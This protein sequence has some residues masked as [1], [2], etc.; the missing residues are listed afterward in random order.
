MP[1]YLILTI[2]A[3]LATGA[4]AVPCPDPS[5]PSWSEQNEI[6]DGWLATRRA[7]LLEM[8]RRHGVDWWIVVNEEFHDDPLTEYVAPARPYAGNR[9]L[10]IFIDTGSRLRAVAISGYAEEVLARWFESPDEPRP[11]TE[12]LP[13][14]YA[15]HE[16]KRIAISSGGRR[17]VTR[18]LTHDAWAMLRETLG[19]EAVKKFVPAEP[20]IEEYLD[21]RL[22]G[23]R[24]LYTR[25]VALTDAMVRRALSSE[26]VEPGVT[27]AADLRDF[28]YDQLWECRVGTW[29]QPDIRIQR[30]GSEAR[31]SRGFL[32]V[33]KEADV[34]LPGDLLHIDF[35]IRFMGLS[36][37]WQKMAYV[38]REGEIEAPAGLRRALERTN[39]LQDVL[40]NAAR[41]GKA[42]GDVYE[43]TMAEMKR[44]G[45]EA[46]IYSHPLGAQ[47]HG[48]GASIDFRSSERDAGAPRKPLRAGS[49]MAIELNTALSVPEWDGKEVR[50]M[51][52]DP[53]ELTEAGYRFFVPRQEAFYLIGGGDQVV[54]NR[55]AEEMP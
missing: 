29:F 15:E 8:M 38:L 9:D 35:G 12:V 44:R 22:A 5:L 19:H 20:L 43:E 30:A 36:T 41:P 54:A 55:E 4:F 48:L 52:E 49:W 51:Q 50:I 2:T 23:E 40:M 28:L 47:G 1:R 45:I 10:F 16:P 39:V 42:A 18:S 14:L 32:A 46:R 25:L 31:S 3:L 7:G 33:A 34:I 13:A 37:D 11:A 21:T 26:T 27:T 6:R 17:G 24:A 53:A